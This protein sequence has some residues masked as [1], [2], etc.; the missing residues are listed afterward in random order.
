[1]NNQQKNHSILKV[2]LITLTIMFVTI[3][4]EKTLTNS[5]TAE[6]KS[7]DPNR[8][9]DAVREFADNVLKYGRDTYGPKH[10]PLFVDGVNVNTHEPVKWRY[11]GQVWILSNLASQQ[12]LLRTLDGLSKITGDPKYKQAAIEAIKYELSN[13]QTP[14]GLLYW[15]G[16]LAYDA[17]GDKPTRTND[18]HELKHNYPYY[19]LMWQVDANSTKKFIEAFWSAHILDWS[20]LAMNRHGSLSGSLEIPWMHEYERGPVFFQSSG[21]SFLNTGSDLFYAGSILSKLS[22]QSEPLIW[23]KRLAQRYIDTRNPKTGISGTQYSVG[24][25]DPAGLQFGDD[26]EGHVVLEGTLFPY[27]LSAFALANQVKEWICQIRLG[28]ILGSDGTEFNQWALDEL[29]AWGKIAY[30]QEDNSFIPMLTDGTSFEKYVYT[31]DGYFGPK[32]S[33]ITAIAASPICFWAYALAYRVTGDQFMWD[34]ARNIAKGNGFGDIGETI[35]D[36]PQVEMSLDCSDPYALL[37]FLELHQRGKKK[38]FLNIASRIGD[39]IISDRFYMGFFIPSKEALYTKFDYIEPLALLSLETTISE[40][41]SLIPQIWPSSSF[42]ACEYDG[43]GGESK[44]DTRVIYCQ[45]NQTELPMLLRS[46]VWAGKY[47][48]VEALISRGIDVNAPCKLDSEILQRIVGAQISP[49]DTWVDVGLTNTTTA[50]HYAAERGHKE[51]VELLI[52]KGADINAKNATGDTSL[53]FAVEAGERE[54]AELLID[55][56]AEVNA[57]NVQGQTPLDII[58][59]QSQY[60][61]SRNP[62]QAEIRV[63]LLANG[64]EILSIHAAVKSGDI[65]KVKE[66]LE[67]GTDINA[68]DE[69]GQTSLYIAVNNDN[70]ETVKL[71]ID[72]GADVNA[73]NEDG[74]TPLDIIL[75]RNRIQIS[76]N[77][78]HAEIR[79]LLIANGAEILSIHAAVQSGDLGQVKEFL[80]QGIDINSKNSDGDTALHIAVDR[81]YNDVA[82]LLIDKG[83]DVN[84]KDKRNET[85]LYN[86]IYNSNKD[87]VSL[88]VNKGADVNFSASEGDSILYEAIWMD[89]FD[90]VK[91]LVDNGAKY[92]VKDKDGLT[93]LYEAIS[94]GSMDMVKLFISKGIDKYSIHMA[95]CAGDLAKVQE[96]IE[97]G[98]A[99]DAN[100]AAGW[101]ALVW[102]VN[103]GQTDVAEFLINN[104]ANVNVKYGRQNQSLLHSAIQ[105]DSVKLIELLI[106]KGINVNVKNRAG[107]TP[108]YAAVL[109]G[110]VDVVKFLLDKGADVNVSLGARGIGA[111]GGMSSMTLLNMA[112]RRGNAEI[113]E[114]L[115]KNG[116][117]E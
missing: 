53:H 74:Q 49:Y 111:R 65:E 92:D 46:A 69:N 54:I 106:E 12:N 48:E 55:N 84:A 21:L 39:N 2:I 9:L 13:L 19:E 90:I 114:L 91:I 109:R 44:E 52:A 73:K 37:G 43:S 56:G 62:N 89:D 51:I 105:T 99:V 59:N 79:D 116:A 85:P 18:N 11:N 77:P 117:T 71:L 6:T 82:K 101:T 58:L 17:L 80:E 25:E 28:E 60:Q 93:A 38:P 24:R 23:S 94:Q 72:K 5:T 27:D 64:A 67:Q 95:A 87:L 100:D 14:N 97:Q 75:N 31:K 16:H 88:L 110:R 66:F 8:Y 81:D 3:G 47:E 86:A 96:F 1:M 76:R 36:E 35:T 34:M 61:I 40:N 41:F 107:Q 26:F 30:R 63:L 112:Q 50:L 113:V 103:A 78:N 68:K 15:G 10:T 57:K 108:L 4:C 22:G 45:T 70:K 104:N 32:G 7:S 83:A 102:A 33:F 42:F 20:N 29:T 115:K 98:T